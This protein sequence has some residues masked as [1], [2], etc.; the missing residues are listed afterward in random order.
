M[1]FGWGIEEQ[2]NK[3]TA[4]CSILGDWKREDLARALLR[5]LLDDMIIEVMYAVHK[6]GIKRVFFC[7]SMV[8]CEFLRTEM[9]TALSVKWA[10]HPEV[11]SFICILSVLFFYVVYCSK[12]IDYLL[13]IKR[14]S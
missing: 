11:C 14:G 1:A 3:T 5:K 9:M 8:D 6:H 7:G 2:G 12:C 10:I 4:S 13:F